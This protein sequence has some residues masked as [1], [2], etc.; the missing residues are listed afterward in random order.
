VEE[1]GY[2]FELSTHSAKFFGVLI[3]IALNLAFAQT[4]PNCFMR[5]TNMA[6]AEHNCVDFNHNTISASVMLM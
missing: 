5:A 1:H 4:L 3:I 2:L 6:A